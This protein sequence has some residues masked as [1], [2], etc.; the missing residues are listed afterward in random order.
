MAHR[1][2]IVLAMRSRLAF[3]AAACTVAAALLPAVPALAATA[4]SDVW[5]DAYGV[6]L[7]AA[8]TTANIVTVARA[9]QGFAVTDTAAPLR[10]DLGR[11]GRCA[12]AGT[13]TVTCTDAGLRRE[14][15]IESGDG[16]DRIEAGASDTAV[17]VFAGDGADQVHGSTRSD[18]MNGGDGN[19]TL[20]GGEGYDSLFGGNGSD[21]L[22]GDAGNDWLDGDAGSDDVHGGDGDDTLLNASGTRDDFWGDDGDDDMESANR[23]WAG[24]GD[25]TILVRWGF[26]DFYGQAGHDVLDYS[27]WPYPTLVMSMDGNDNDGEVMPSCP[28]YLNCPGDR[29]GRHNVHGDFE[30]VIGSPGDDHLTGNNEADRLDGRGG[31]DRLFGKGGDDV[32]DAGPGQDQGTD[33]GS[34][35]DTCRGSG[36]TSRVGCDLV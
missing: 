29:N 12:Q 26:G 28:W 11:A 2:G 8:G 23:M 1:A 21:T 22:R 10:L 25:D 33:G 32:L 13:N 24:D 35:T 14:L 4:P 20:S 19:D 31:R 18:W 6:Y 30:H 27:H 36:V 16:N 15:Q 17:R 3:S 5:A 9:G 7:R 34:G